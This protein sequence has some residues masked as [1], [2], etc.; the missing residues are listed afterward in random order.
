MK[1]TIARDDPY[2]WSDE[3]APDDEPLDV[4][5]A[6]CSACHL[7]RPV[8]KF[9]SQSLCRNCAQEAGVA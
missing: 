8:R 9:G 3:Y 5:Y 6:L 4:E 2:E 1:D 7:I